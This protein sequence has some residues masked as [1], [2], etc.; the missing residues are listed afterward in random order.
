MAATNRI[1]PYACKVQIM[2]MLFSLYIVTFHFTICKEKLFSF[3]NVIFD[4][5]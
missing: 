5:L 2:C 1:F 4:F 3:D